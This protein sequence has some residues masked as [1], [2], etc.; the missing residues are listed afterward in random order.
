MTKQIVVFN[1]Q[2]FLNADTAASK[3]T[4]PLRDG[5]GD[6]YAVTLRASSGIVS[7]GT[8]APKT[9]SKTADYTLANTETT[10]FVDATS[11]A[12]A[13][14]MPAA[15]GATDRLYMVCKTDSGTN[16][17]AVKDSDGSTT[18]ATLSAQHDA[19]MFQSDGTNWQ[20]LSF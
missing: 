12:V 20:L 7:G 2:T 19:A 14:T 10:C 16:A 5:S 9:V 4:A 3:N 8:F 13:I 11:A 18:L 15:S 1:E 17:V 6:L